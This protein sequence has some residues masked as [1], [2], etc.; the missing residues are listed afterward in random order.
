MQADPRHWLLVAIR[1]LAGVLAFAGLW[2]A[3]IGWLGSAHDISLGA[4]MMELNQPATP[5]RPG[6]IANG[7]ALLARRPSEFV[8]SAARAVVSPP[9]ITGPYA[10]LIQRTAA[11]HGVDPRLVRAIIQVESAF[12]AEALSPQGAMG[13]MQLSPDIAER[14]AVGNPF[15]PGANLEA[16]IRHLRSLLDRFELSLALAAYNAGE[17]AVDHFRGIPPYPETRMFVSQ[18]LTLVRAKPSR[19]P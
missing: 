10:A 16:G 4:G 19:Q 2:A 14:Y 18:V 6:A 3:E 1:L 8:L 5:A 13:L 9:P 15:D 11:R 12:Q 17:A 7:S